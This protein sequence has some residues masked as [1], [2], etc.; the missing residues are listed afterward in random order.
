MHTPHARRRL[1]ELVAASWPGW[2]L[3]FALN[4]FFVYLALLDVVNVQPRTA[5]TGAWY[6]G[7]GALCLTATWPNRELLRRRLTSP[8]T[9]VRVY[10]VAA[11]LLAAW[12]IVNVLVLSRS[13]LAL[14]FAALLVAWSLP[15]AILAASSPARQLRNAAWAIVVLGG[16]YVLVEAAAVLQTGSDVNRFTP[17]ASLDPISAG[18]IAGLAAVAILALQPQGRRSRMI[19]AIALIAFVAGATLPGSRGPVVATV[20]GC[21]A[22]TLVAWRRLWF[23]ALVGLVVGL[24]IGTVLARDVGSDAYLMQSLPGLEET[25]APAPAPKLVA[26]EP[27]PM[28][29]ETIST[30]KIRR[31]WFHAAMAKAPE[32]PIFGHGVAEFV[33]DTPEAHRMGIAGAHIYP[34]N[35]LAEAAFSLGLLGL[36]PYLAFVVT[37]FWAFMG[38]VRRQSEDV[39]LAAALGGFAFVATNVSGEIGADAV[40]WAASA[41]LVALYA[42]RSFASS[43]PSSPRTAVVPSRHEFVDS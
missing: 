32:R 41:S 11:T 13:S 30:F 43:R 29:I 20:G 42:D 24:A 21:I 3:G 40:L 6:A 23:V 2:T 38:L 14:K 15:A 28:Q 34:H 1:S 31:E 19:H 37:G 17:I 4:G 18:L 33:D 10:V 8:N 5:I 26:G 9:T 36:V 27:N 12:F 35:T 16:F 39:V 7:I 22:G 25:P